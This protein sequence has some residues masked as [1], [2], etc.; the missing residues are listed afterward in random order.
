MVSE[1]CFDGIYNELFDA[2]F[3]HTDYRANPEFG[4]DLGEVH[5]IRMIAVINRGF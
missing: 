2:K 1:F 4:V 5:H 3:C